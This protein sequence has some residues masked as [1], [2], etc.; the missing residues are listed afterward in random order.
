[1]VREGHPITLPSS[2]SEPEPDLAIVHGVELNSAEWVTAPLSLTRP[3]PGDTV[4][5]VCG[6]D[7]GKIGTLIDRDGWRIQNDVFY[8]WVEDLSQ[9]RL[10]E[11]IAV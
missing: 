1:M 6:P 2:N 3:Q 8:G 5:I 4:E 9:V 7:S 10:Y 11:P